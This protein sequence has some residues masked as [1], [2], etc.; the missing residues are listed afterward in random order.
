MTRPFKFLSSIDWKVTRWLVAA[1]GCLLMAAIVLS[2]LQPD[3]WYNG[4][5][6]AQ[7]ERVPIVTELETE[8][9]V[10]AVLTYGGSD[11]A[12]SCVPKIP[13]LFDERPLER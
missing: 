1:I 5:V 10:C 6:E 13:G 8:R 11:V 4:Q 12:I 3:G 2:T 9:L 7:L